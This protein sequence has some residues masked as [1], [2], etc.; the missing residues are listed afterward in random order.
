MKGVKSSGKAVYFT[1][2][3]PYV[4][5]IILMIFGATL[6]GADIGLVAFFKPDVKHDFS[7]FLS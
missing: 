2:V 1:A 7:N 6:S 4:I 3:F 5:F